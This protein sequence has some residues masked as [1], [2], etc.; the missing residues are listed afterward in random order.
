MPI[1]MYMPGQSDEFQI[2]AAVTIGKRVAK[3]IGKSELLAFH[4]L[5]YTRVAKLPETRAWRQWY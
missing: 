5:V 4:T 1:K 2:P 3:Y